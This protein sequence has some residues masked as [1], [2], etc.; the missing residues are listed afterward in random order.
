MGPTHDGRIDLI[1]Q[2]RLFDLGKWLAVNG[3]AIYKSTP[4]KHQNDTVTGSV[5]YT[6]R[7][8]TVFAISLE[9]PKN[10]TLKLG[11]AVKLFEN[12]RPVVTML[13]NSDKLKVINI[14]S[15]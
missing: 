5:W 6:S 3:K 9:W 2:E 13:G 12:K 8:P 15:L 7:K 4:W 10:N 11:S 14:E 1:F